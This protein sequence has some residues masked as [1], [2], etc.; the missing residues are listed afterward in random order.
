MIAFAGDQAKI[1]W[2]RE[3]GIDRVANYK[4]EDVSK[5]LAE[6][7]PKGINCYFD[8]VNRN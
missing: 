3:L 6:E 1:A 4:T 5:V 7:A 2:L 8:N